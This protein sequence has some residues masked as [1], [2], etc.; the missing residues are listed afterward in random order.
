MVGSGQE[1]M[2]DFDTKKFEETLENRPKLKFYLTFKAL[3]DWET[4]EVE[5]KSQGMIFKDVEK[6]WTDDMIGVLINEANSLGALPE[7]EV[8]WRMT[9]FADLVERS[10]VNVDM[11]GVDKLLKESPDYSSRA[12]GE[13]YLSLEQV[14]KFCSVL[15]QKLN[16]TPVSLSVQ[17]SNNKQKI[18]NM[19]LRL[20]ARRGVNDGLVEDFF[21]TKK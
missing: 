14:E 7:S 3:S 19:I 15:L 17:A 11:I 20:E 21:R 9:V 5:L 4:A 8:E 16:E 13:S 10:L 12:V 1:P 2:N 6:K 18:E